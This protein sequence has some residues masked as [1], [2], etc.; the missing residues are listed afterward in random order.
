MKNKAIVGIALSDKKK[1]SDKIPVIL[2]KARFDDDAERRYAQM[3][4]Y[5]PSCV[6]NGKIFCPRNTDAQCLICGQSFCGAHIAVHLHERHCVSLDL[7]HCMKGE[8]K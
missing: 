6:E 8:K 2:H 3:M 4:K 7:E 5:C 1:K